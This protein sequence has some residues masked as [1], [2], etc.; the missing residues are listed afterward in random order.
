MIGTGFQQPVFQAQS[1]FRAILD[2]LA[3]PGT[4]QR[5]GA[6]QRSGDAVEA[7]APLSAGTAA[8][9]LTL[10][11]HD[12]PVWLDGGLRSNDEVAQWLRFHCGCPLVEN[13][14]DA[15]FAF[16]SDIGNLPPFEAFG[17]GTAEYPDRSTTVVLQVESFERGTKLTLEGPGIRGRTSFSAEP[18]PQDIAARLAA[19][20]ALFPRGVDLLLATASAVAG[21]PRSV[22]IVGD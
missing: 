21:L 17:L 6:V 16:A 10:C 4:V 13:P 22:R 19:N 12:T 5:L 15:A 1:A 3:R 9:A 8:V 14:R 2:A 11:D 20:R 7:P 18:L